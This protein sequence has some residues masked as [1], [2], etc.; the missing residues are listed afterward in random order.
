MCVN[1]Y[2]AVAGIEIKSGHEKFVILVNGGRQ[3][4]KQGK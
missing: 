2:S 1:Y 3:V 4:K